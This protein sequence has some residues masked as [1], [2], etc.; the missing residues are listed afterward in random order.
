MLGEIGLVVS[1]FCYRGCGGGLFDCKDHFRLISINC[2]CILYL[3]FDFF[4][5]HGK[6]QLSFYTVSTHLYIYLG[7]GGVCPQY[8]YYPYWS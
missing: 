8:S 5:L 1:P 6:T 3:V 2:E 7:G 4:S